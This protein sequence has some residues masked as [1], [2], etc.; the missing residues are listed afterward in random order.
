MWEAVLLTLLAAAGNNIGKVLQKKGTKGLP[1]L[2]LDSKIL[3]TYLSSRT[4]VLGLI[5]DVSGALL[6][7]QAVAR[8]PVSVVQPVSGCG[9]AILAIFSHFYLKEALYPR[10]WIG[11]TA[12]ALGTVGVGLTAEEQISKAVSWLRMVIFVFELLIVLVLVEL[13]A[14]QVKLHRRQLE[15]PTPVPSIGAHS[16]DVLEEVAAGL[17]AASRTG[18]LL[19]QQGHSKLLAPLGI[20]TSIGLSS[21]GFICQ[22]RG[23]KEGRAVVVS[24]S[25]AAAAILVG[26]TVG[27]FALG[28]AFPE[29]FVARGLQLAS[30]F[31]ILV[32]MM[33]LLQQGKAGPTFP[34]MLRMLKRRRASTGRTLTRSASL[35]ATPSPPPALK[36]P[37]KYNE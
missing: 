10:D 9:L 35:I 25:A 23:F 13:G 17:Q 32:G 5:V 20:A 34:R 11:I 24:T 30:W 18:F 3:Y 19:V 26:V 33:L 21:G 27:L 22:T 15:L 28:E 12:A 1:R 31:C 2:T 4:W 36:P 6:M 14:H 16:A 7:L 29:G 37:V 8:A